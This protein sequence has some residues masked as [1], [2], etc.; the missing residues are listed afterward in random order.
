MRGAADGGRARR[1]ARAR[2]HVRG[3]LLGVVVMTLGGAAGASSLLDGAS[4]DPA[5]RGLHLLRDREGIL[6]VQANLAERTAR[7][8]GRRLYRLLL[9]GA[10]ERVA[11]IERGEARAQEGPAGRSGGRAISLSVAVLDRDLREAGVLRAELARVRQER[12]A[13]ASSA[14]DQAPT[15]VTPPPDATPPPAGAPP[16]AASASP[17]GLS[18]LS[19]PPP[20]M[21]AP[22]PGPPVLPFGVARDDS[23][24]AWI[25]R[26]AAGFAAKPK[27]PVRATSDGRVERI[28]SDGADGLAVVLSHA[29]GW[30]TVLSG[31]GAVVVSPREGVAR[32]GIIGFAPR[33]G[34]S[35]IVRVEVW[36]GR[37][38]MDPVALLRSP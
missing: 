16:P 18:P 7:A 13:A 20:R 8:R 26:A 21:L 31:L 17:S 5:G 33:A 19:T 34:G 10:A 27:Q 30:T 38:P 9:L 35:G 1:R 23:T 36:R 25:F 32:G 29:G 15:G 6:A 24:G 3:A 28:E 12:E 4:A 11:G 37:Q 22:V 2:T 14:A